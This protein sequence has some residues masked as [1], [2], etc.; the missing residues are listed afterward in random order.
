QASLSGSAH[1][2]YVGRS[3]RC[4]AG[5][6]GNGPVARRGRDSRVAFGHVLYQHL[7]AACLRALAHSDGELYVGVRADLS[8][9]LFTEPGGAPA[10]GKAAAKRAERRGENAWAYH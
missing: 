5:R 1:R 3:D 10:S 7:A 9:R 6:Y 2:H 8:G 4:P